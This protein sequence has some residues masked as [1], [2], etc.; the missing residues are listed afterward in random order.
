M[1]YGG[2]TGFLSVEL[3]S[4]T[5]TLHDS[6]FSE[7]GI[8]TDLAISQ[9]TT[10]DYT[11]IVPVG[12]FKDTGKLFVFP[13]QRG[14]WTFRDSVERFVQAGQ[15]W[16]GIVGVE[17]VAYQKAV[18]QELRRISNITFRGIKRTLDKVTRA[19]RLAAWME[20]GDVIFGPGTGPLIDELLP[21]PQGQHDDLFDSLEMA[22]V[23]LL[24]MPVGLTPGAYDLNDYL[25]DEDEEKKE[26]E[27]EGERKPTAW[28][29]LDPED[30]TWA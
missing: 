5:V 3:G 20:R 10:A 9:A 13:V 2:P 21:F 18:S 19:Y 28:D 7:V 1:R 6:A 23:E 27:S 4:D 29:I 17:E 8:G 15:D 30:Q 11:T 25:P 26:K 22:I 12:K 24:G 14:R 16:N